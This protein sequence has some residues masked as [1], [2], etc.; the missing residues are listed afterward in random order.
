MQQW[1]VFAALIVGYIT[2]TRW[3]LPKLGIPT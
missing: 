3:V 2:L 1:L